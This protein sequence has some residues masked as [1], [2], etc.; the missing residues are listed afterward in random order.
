[1][2]NLKSMFQVSGEGITSVL[3]MGGA[4]VLKE[5]FFNRRESCMFQR[6]G[7]TCSVKTF[8]A[9][10]AVESSWSSKESYNSVGMR[11]S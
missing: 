5:R 11:E 9:D 6:G 8:T 4:T 10:V 3:E 7:N 1:M 2:A